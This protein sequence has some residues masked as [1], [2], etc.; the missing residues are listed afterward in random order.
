[1][2]LTCHTDYALRLL[3]YLQ[4]N[5]ECVSVAEVARSFGISRHHLAKVAQELARRGWIQTQRGRGGG[6]RMSSETG[7]VTVGAVVRA[8]EPLSLVECQRGAE[9]SCPIAPACSLTCMLHEATKA[10]LAVLD[11]HSIASLAEQPERLR[12]LLHPKPQSPA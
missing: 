6:I 1:M 12:A 7:Q 5:P 11:Q 8:L 3:I 2:Q 9:N 10:F 4:V